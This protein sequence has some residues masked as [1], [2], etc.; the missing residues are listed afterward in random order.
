MTDARCEIPRHS[1]LPATQ[2]VITD[3]T[4]ADLFHCADF[5]TG[6]LLRKPIASGENDPTAWRAEKWILGVLAT[7]LRLIAHEAGEDVPAA[8]RTFGADPVGRAR[9]QVEEM[10]ALHASSERRVADSEHRAA[11][12]AA[13]IEQSTTEGAS[14]EEV[15]A[16]QG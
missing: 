11:R 13:A 5:L 4:A 16:W 6:L 14:P 10:A 1:L 2:D 7:E 12:L 15:A 3:L 9:A 8:P